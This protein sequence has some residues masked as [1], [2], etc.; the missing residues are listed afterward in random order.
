MAPY[1]GDLFAILR[2][3]KG[4]TIRQVARRCRWGKID[5]TCKQIDDF[6]FGE[7][8]DPKRVRQLFTIVGIPEGEVDEFLAQARR[9]WERWAD[10]P[11]TPY[12]V[13]RLI[14]TV[15]SRLDIPE[16]LHGD[17]AAMER[18]V[19][20]FAKRRRFRVCLVLSRRH[21]IWIGIDGER[22]NETFD[23]FEEKFGPRT[24]FG[25][26]YDSVGEAAEMETMFRHKDLTIR[27]P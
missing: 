22:E 16:D 17:A 7:R 11:I 25:T 21:R 9:E 3:R 10:E 13:V 26:D 12:A 2:I 20:D 24:R 18:F 27:R 14:S 4:L 1:L 23:T 6:E 19:A 8:L 5:D 15:Y